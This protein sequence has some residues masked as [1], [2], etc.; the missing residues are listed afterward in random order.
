M[1]GVEKVTEEAILQYF[2][3]KD[4][5]QELVGQ[6][7]EEIQ[8]LRESYTKPQYPLL[9]KCYFDSWELGGDCNTVTASFY[10]N[11]Q[12]GGTRS[13]QFPIQ[14]LTTDNWEDTERLLLNHEATFKAIEA[15]EAA[16][17]ASRLQREDELAE[18]KKLQEKYPEAAAE[19]IHAAAGN[20]Y[21]VAHIS[22]PDLRWNFS[23]GWVNKDDTFDLFES[24]QAKNFVLPTDGVWKIFK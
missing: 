6:R 22:N 19:I 14:Y 7:A 24:Y 17:K 18:L 4:R 5:L 11:W 10:E 2:A 13:V 20:T 23:R 8:K 15:T 16:A 9:D 3:T 21:A 1:S 12:G